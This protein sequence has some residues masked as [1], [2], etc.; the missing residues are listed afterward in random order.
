MDRRGSNREV[1][2]GRWEIECDV[3][4]EVTCVC[5][6]FCLYDTAPPSSPF[7]CSGDVHT[8]CHTKCQTAS[9]LSTALQ[10]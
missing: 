4:W 2:T 8:E 3:T 5:F 10:K 9:R 1:G 7:S 6:L